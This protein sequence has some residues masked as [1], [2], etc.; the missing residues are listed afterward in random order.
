MWIKQRNCMNFLARVR[1]CFWESVR[2]LTGSWTRCV[3]NL[4]TPAA[5]HHINNTNNNSCYY[6]ADVNKSLPACC[7]H[8]LDWALDSRRT[9]WIVKKCFANR[10]PRS[11]SGL[12]PLNPSVTSP[13]FKGSAF[14]PG[15]AE[16]SRAKYFST[17]RSSSPFSPRP[18]PSYGL[19]Q[20]QLEIR[21]LFFF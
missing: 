18:R 12:H 19:S 13:A 14:P 17:W 8:G 10:S 9:C 1:L 15:F 2:H 16:H 5:Y 3:R 20:R 7:P 6:Q 21:G 11:R 4:L